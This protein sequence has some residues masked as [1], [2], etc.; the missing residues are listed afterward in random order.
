MLFI[1]I[2]ILATY[3]R[4]RQALPAAD[5]AR[6]PIHLPAARTL[7]WLGIVALAAIAVTTHVVEGL[8]YAAVSFV[9]CLGVLTMIYF[10]RRRAAA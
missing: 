5:I 4:F 1:W 10:G 9:V 7:P 3:L 8:E 6:L 2:V